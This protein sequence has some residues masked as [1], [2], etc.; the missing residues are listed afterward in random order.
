MG[1]ATEERRQHKRYELENSVSISSQGIFQ[2]A[3]IGRGGFCFTC[4]PYT[5]IKDFWV[6]DIISSVASLEGFPAKR[7]WV[8]IT[9]NGAHE[10]LP[11]VVGVKFGTLTKNQ[12]T[13]LQQ[14]LVIL[15]QSSS[16]LH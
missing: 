15:E 6:T 9:E 14:L 5:P 2:V 12:E 7:V 4:P 16:T 3:D 8:S 1:P 13:I 11:T 10:Y